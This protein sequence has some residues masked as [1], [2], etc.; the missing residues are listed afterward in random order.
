MILGIED[1]TGTIIT[2]L[3]ARVVGPEVVTVYHANSESEHED[4]NTFTLD[5]PIA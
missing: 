2:G 1:A 5:A 3:Q 4:G